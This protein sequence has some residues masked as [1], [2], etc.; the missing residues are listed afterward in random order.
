MHRRES[1]LSRV[2][3]L[4]VILSAVPAE[5]IADQAV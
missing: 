2:S 5:S 1:L 4:L 3:E